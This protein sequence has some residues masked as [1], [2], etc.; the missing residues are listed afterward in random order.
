MCGNMSTEVTEKC[1]KSSKSAWDIFF[2]KKNLSQ[3]VQVAGDFTYQHCWECMLSIPDPTRY[4]YCAEIN[5]E[6]PDIRELQP[7]LYKQR[8]QKHT[9]VLRTIQSQGW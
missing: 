6:T 8:R 1:R 5:P 9:A 3:K 7:P 2:H 4:T